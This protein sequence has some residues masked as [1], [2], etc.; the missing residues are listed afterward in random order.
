MIMF[1]PINAG[2]TNDTWCTSCGHKITVSCEGIKTVIIT[3]PLSSGKQRTR[4]KVSKGYVEGQPLPDKGTCSHYKKSMRWFRFTCCERLFPCDK[5]HDA[6]FPDCPLEPA[7]RMVCGLCA[8]EQ[9]VRGQCKFCHG[10]IAGNIRSH[11]W[12]GGKGCRDQKRMSNNDPK[13]HKNSKL[14]TQSQKDKRVGK[15]KETTS[16]QT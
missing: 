4:T 9:P 1:L 3:P 8:K 14:K 12:E 11:H 13:K 15:K 7:N 6:Q 5:C 2:S 16:D 10:D